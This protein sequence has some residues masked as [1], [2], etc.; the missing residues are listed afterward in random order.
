METI[1][2]RVDAG[3]FLLG[4]FCLSFQTPEQISATAA[5]AVSKV[6]ICYFLET[7]EYGDAQSERILTLVV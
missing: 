6:R 5:P 4:F 3:G 2:F 7:G 1:V